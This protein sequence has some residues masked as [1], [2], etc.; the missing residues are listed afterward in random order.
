[1][2]YA[3]DIEPLSIDLAFWFLG[4]ENPDF[5]IEQ[6]GG[7]SHEL[8]HKFRSLAIMQLLAHGST[9]AFLFE[10]GD[11]GTLMVAT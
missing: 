10:A 5:P 7:L 4:L 2:A 6:L 8:A 11:V 9:D 1:M 3:D